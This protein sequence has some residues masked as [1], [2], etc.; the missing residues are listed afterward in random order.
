MKSKREQVGKYYM[1]FIIALWFGFEILNN[2]TLEKILWWEKN[3]VDYV[4]TYL[5]FAL[6]IVQIVIFQ[7]YS[8][9]EIVKIAILTFPIAIGTIA[10]NNHVMMSTWMFI[11]A[12][13]YI[14]FDTTAKI[15][16]YLLLCL[17]PLVIYMYFLGY[18]DERILYRGSVV[19]HSWG[20]SHPNWF[21]VRIFQVVTLRTFL[22]RQK[23]TIVDYGLILL[24]AL[25]I[26]R[27]TDCQTA[28][29]SLLLLLCFMLFY[30]FMGSFVG[31]N[32]FFFSIMLFVGVISNIGSVFLSY[33]DVRKYRI[34]NYFDIIMS[35]RFTHCHKAIR[36]YGIPLLG[37]DINLYS[38]YLR[39]TFRRFYID[40][41]YVAIIL[42][43][44]FIVYIL[45]SIIY[46]LAMI[47][48]KNISNYMLLIIL[49]IYSIYGVMENSF[50][51]LNQNIFLL[52]LSY[53][54]YHRNVLEH[55]S[56]KQINTKRKLLISYR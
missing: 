48:S 13:R 40:T 6:L 5:I 12:S 4:M 24:A 37:K 26:K 8:L 41:A 43:Y 44:G 22:R 54:L 35:K 16:Y 46:L 56:L 20:F 42:R 29:Y 14:D 31:G 38:T 52:T 9:D 49:C 50:Y 28:F 39:H 23:I 33:I 15:T 2:T 34:L 18:I 7:R 45:F 17:I 27:V 30:W 21:G 36:Y 19:R 53:A 10:S 1:Y 55:V 32:S 3:D 11:V 47:K 25:F 51:A